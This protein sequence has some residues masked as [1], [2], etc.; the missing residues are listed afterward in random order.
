MA[1]VLHCFAALVVLLLGREAEMISQSTHL[2]AS[3]GAVDVE[4][5]PQDSSLDRGVVLLRLK[6]DSNSS[7][8]AYGTEPT[9]AA[10]T[11]GYKCPMWFIPATNGQDGCQCGSSVG[12]VV[13]CDEHSTRLSIRECFCMTYNEDKTS[14]V[15]GQCVYGCLVP[16]TIPFYYAF[17]ASDPKEICKNL[18][19]VGQ[20]CGQCE[21]N[22]APPVY[23]YDMKCVECSSTNIA[24]NWV[25][26][27][28]VS[29]LPLTVFFIAV[30]AFGIRAASP[31]LNAFVLVS[32]ILTQP[33]Q[34][35]QVSNLSP[36]TPLLW[37]VLTT[38]Y[39]VWNLDFFRTVYPPFCL[40][41]NMTVLQILALD[42]LIAGY[43]LLLIAVTYGIVVIYDRCSF[44]LLRRV[45]DRL[46]WCKISGVSLAKKVHKWDIRSSLIGAFATFILLSYVKFLSVSADLLTGVIVYDINGTRWNQYYFFY[47]GSVEF[48]GETHLPYA[49]AALF[50]IAVF[51]VLPI[52]LLCLYPCRYFRRLLHYT[53]LWSQG[54]HTFMDAFQG[55][56][57]N[58]TEEGYDCRYFAAVYLATRITVYTMYTVLATVFFYASAALILIGVAILT[59]IVRPYKKR[60][61]S[62]IDTTL[63][64]V[65]ALMF[66]LI[67]LSYIMNRKSFELAGWLGVINGALASIPLL[68]IISYMLYL[69][70]TNSN[71]LQ[72]VFWKILCFMKMPNSTL[73][74][75]SLPHRILHADEYERLV[76]SIASDKSEHRESQYTAY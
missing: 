28:T 72:R 25:K 16:T 37:K 49:I 30:V 40:D 64:L 34:M 24:A 13:L 44:R 63:I 59:T 70:Y 47:N 74:S 12:E 50:G 22:F 9:G 52:L 58:G 21:A 33:A 6:N 19:R 56:C 38:V 35:R 45:I 2:Q 5:Q 4:S 10:N 60:V 23:S 53:G 36:Q 42:Y 31:Q 62:A 39:G 73:C 26:Y 43:P 41:P 54:L 75:M 48:M 67:V 1:R 14:P 15:I 20:L 27:L 76:E 57:K 66:F 32:Q 51:N 29:L 65:V 68:Y 61:H 18:H 69:L 11:S 17:N 55:S 46:C 7:I 3:E 71:V 8:A